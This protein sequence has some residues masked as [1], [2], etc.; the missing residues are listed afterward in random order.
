M[1][2]KDLI[3]KFKEFLNTRG[4]WEKFEKE[5]VSNNLA[6]HEF[7]LEIPPEG[8]IDSALDWV[9]SEDGLHF[10]NDI[11]SE[12][13]YYLDVLENQEKTILKESLLN[14]LDDKRVVNSRL[15][16]GGWHIIRKEMVE[17]LLD[18]YNITIK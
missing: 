8:W 11:D 14:D 6:M 16:K 2:R 9:N 3:K 12:W 7:F 18:K 10:W 1:K 13:V 17:C 15:T 5:Y 4:V